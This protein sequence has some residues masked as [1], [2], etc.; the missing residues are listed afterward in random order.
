ME[1]HAALVDILMKNQPTPVLRAAAARGLAVQPGFEMLIQQTHLYL[2]F[3]GFHEAAEAMKR[4]C[5][6][7][8]ESI[9]SGG[10]PGEISHPKT[11]PPHGVAQDNPPSINL[12]RLIHAKT[13]CS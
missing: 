3:F 10:L 6:F 8:R 12:R 9:S 7:V 4:D 5:S 2:E 13:I 11:T 1:P